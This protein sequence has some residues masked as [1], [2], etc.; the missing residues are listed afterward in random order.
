MTRPP[1]DWIRTS[2]LS[3]CLTLALICMAP[4]IRADDVSDRLDA[5]VK[6][7]DALRP[8]SGAI[9]V[10]RGDDVLLARGFGLANAEHEVPNTPETRLRLGSIT[11]QFTATAILILQD[12]GLLK[13][14]DP[15]SRH[16]EN[17]PDAWKSVTIHHLLTHTSGIPSYTDSPDYP[18]QMM[19][20]E[21]VQTMIGRF[22][23][24]PLDFEPGSQFHYD[25]SGYFLL[26]AIIE[27][28]S[29]ET[30]ADFLH[31]A[32]F[33]PLE[34][35]NTGYDLHESVIPNRASGYDRVGGVLKNAPYLDMHQP[36]AAG[37]LYSTVGDLHKWDRALKAG[38]LLTPSS[39]KAMFTPEKNNY[40]YG[41]QVSGK[42][43]RKK[44]GHG[45]GINGFVTQFDRFPDDD[46]CVVVLCNVQPYNPGRL[47]DSLGRIAMGDDV[48]MPRERKAVPLDAA[49]IDTYVG[50]YEIKP[51]LILT[52]ERD[53]D[54][55][56]VQVTGQ[57]KFEVLAESAVNFFLKAMDAEFTV[58]KEGNRI[59]GLIVRQ[60]GKVVEAK[61]LPD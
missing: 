22:R 23:D 3:P 48:P 25:N 53:A 26:G 24:K 50:R 54:R 14:S 29:G 32:I 55:M 27:A 11:K 31:T 47:S 44:V 61:R 13:V 18:K 52:L 43:G 5:Y 21:T 7:A 33:G 49:L 59:S 46:V 30:Y 39:M 41:W 4:A 36:Y 16:L 51:G 10:A 57:G 34:M 58:V 9:L 17:T 19:M 12:R 2:F 56:T 42:T 38:R 37:S 40:A 1:Q 45:G 20:P 35:E 15:I 60:G 6:A 8:F 28:V